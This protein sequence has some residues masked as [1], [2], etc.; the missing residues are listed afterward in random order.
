MK[1]L[2]QICANF[3]LR[4]KYSRNKEQEQIPKFSKVAGVCSKIPQQCPSPISNLHKL[5]NSCKSFASHSKQQLYQRMCATSILRK[6]YS[7]NREQ[8]QIPKFSKVAGVCSKIPQQCPSPI[9]NL[10]KLINSCQKFCKSF[11]ATTLP[12]NL[13]NIH[14]APNNTTARCVV[15]DLLT[16]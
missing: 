10:H 12:T 2:Q 7:R 11:D 13:C 5:I 9:S 1:N 8:E 14:F 6:K 4:K 3:I 16:L 15:F